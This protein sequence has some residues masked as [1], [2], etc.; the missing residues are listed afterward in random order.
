MEREEK[1]R[2]KGRD[3]GGS[4]RA[5]T[6]QHGADDHERDHEG[7]GRSSGIPD[8][9]WEMEERKVRRE[10]EGSRRKPRRVEARRIPSPMREI[11]ILRS[12]GIG[13]RA[14]L[15]VTRGIRMIHGDGSER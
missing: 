14:G 3:A 15:Y 13:G 10:E 8:E 2:G 4:S 12:G 1:Q 5:R 11:W 6:P 9:E 7:N